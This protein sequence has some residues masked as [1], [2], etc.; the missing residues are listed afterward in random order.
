MEQIILRAGYTSAFSEGKTMEAGIRQLVY[1]P[2][3]GRQPAWLVGKGS[4]GG[5]NE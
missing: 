5:C 1:K 4:D 3:G 2:C